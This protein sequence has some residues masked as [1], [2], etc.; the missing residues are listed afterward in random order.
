MIEIDLFQLTLILALIAGSIALVLSLL[1]WEI[2]RYSPFGKGVVI[3][4]ILLSLFIIYHVP[5]AIIDANRV[6]VE[7]IKSILH[8][9]FVLYLLFMVRLSLQTN[10]DSEQGVG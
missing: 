3:L 9:G 4:S 1:S 5:L 6:T 2:L 10:T 7:W 8:T